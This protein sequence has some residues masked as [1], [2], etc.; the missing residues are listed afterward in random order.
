M[1]IRFSPLLAIGARTMV[2]TLVLFSIYTLVIGHDAPGGGFAG[3]LLGSAAVLL[4]YLAFGDRGV[5]RLLRLQSET[6]LGIGLLI[7]SGVGVFGL[8]AGDALLESLKLAGALPVV[9]EV[10]LTSVLIFDAGV[11]LIV[12]GLV[13][14]GILR[15]GG[16]VRA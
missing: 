14:G 9:G 7:V 8:L 5:R 12:V 3:G 6:I 1:Y 13:S 16:E 4:V 15:L 2:P 11:Y 10:K